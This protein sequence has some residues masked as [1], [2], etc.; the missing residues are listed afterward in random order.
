MIRHFGKTLGIGLML[1]GAAI[2]MLW[3]DLMIS[4]G[5]RPTQLSRDWDPHYEVKR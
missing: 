2:L 4:N 5:G 3:A 1:V